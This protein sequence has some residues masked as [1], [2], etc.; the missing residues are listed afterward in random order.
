MADDAYTRLQSQLGDYAS[1]KYLDF[2]SNPYIQKMLSTV[3]NDVQNRIAGA[4]AGRGRD[5]T[6]NAY[7]ALVDVCSCRGKG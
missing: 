4:F 1:G 7:F 5:V 2:E 6:G 3:G